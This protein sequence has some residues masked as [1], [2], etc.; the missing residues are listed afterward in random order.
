MFICSTAGD[1]EELVKL[2]DSALATRIPFGPCFHQI[3]HV[4]LPP[5]V[6]AYNNCPFP[7]VGRLNLRERWEPPGG[8]RIGLPRRPYSHLYMSLRSPASCILNLP[9]PRNLDRLAQVPFLS[10]QEAGLGQLSLGGAP[11]YA[12]HR[13]QYHPC[14]VTVV[15]RPRGASVSVIQVQM[16]AQ[17]QELVLL[18]SACQWCKVGL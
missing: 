3:R 2:K 11:S 7:K 16:F 12:R 17:V 8:K 15:A 14:Q 10:F 4:S 1:F 13:P 6:L 9:T 18:P 5:P